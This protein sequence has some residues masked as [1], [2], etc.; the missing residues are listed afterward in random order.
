[1]WILPKVNIT[2]LNGQINHSDQ[3][4]ALIGNAN[5]CM[6]T[7]NWKKLSIRHVQLSEKLE[8]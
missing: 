5:Y 6:A 1:M 3:D 4:R 2:K 7:S 8:Y